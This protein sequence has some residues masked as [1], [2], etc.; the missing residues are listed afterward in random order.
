MYTSAT[1]ISTEANVFA[2]KLMI[3]IYPCAYTLAVHTYSV[4]QQHIS[5][6]VL[7][8]CVGRFYTACS[9]FGMLLACCHQAVGV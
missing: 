3:T 9:I 4:L 6:L 1:A 7:S 5:M 2:G 8:C